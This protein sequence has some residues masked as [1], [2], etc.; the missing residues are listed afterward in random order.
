MI[1]PANQDG[2]HSRTYLTLDPIG[3]S[4]QILL[5]WN[6]LLNLNHTLVEWFL[7]FPLSEL[8]MVTCSIRL[9]LINGLLVIVIWET[10]CQ[11]SDYRLLGAL[12]FWF[13]CSLLFVFHM[14][15]YTI[16]YLL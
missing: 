5:H 14:I 6:Y 11:V 8:Y 3:N 2:C 4:L 9:Q 10:V 13:I 15:F 12:G 16:L 1:L 7:D